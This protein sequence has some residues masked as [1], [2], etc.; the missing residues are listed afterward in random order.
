MS[1][2]P[3]G[4]EVVERRVCTRDMDWPNGRICGDDAFLHVDWGESWGFTCIR[5]TAE[6][7]AKGWVPQQQHELGP[8]CGMPGAVWDEAE[9][10]CYVP[11]DEEPAIVSVDAVVAGGAAR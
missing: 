6:L 7:S 1:L 2:P 10:R 8:D 3:I 5:H 4:G 9:N 11:E